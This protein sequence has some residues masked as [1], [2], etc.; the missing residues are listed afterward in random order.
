MYLKRRIF[1]IYQNQADD[2]TAGGGAGDKGD[3]GNKTGDDDIQTKI[4]AAV[5]TAVEGLT[6]K[7]KQLLAELKQERENLKKFEGIDP[8]KVKELM[9]KFDNDEDTK[10]IKEGKI[11][12][13]LNRKYSKRDAEWQRKLDEANKIA[14]EAKAKADKFLESVL[15]D[16]LR[17]AFNG[18]V[19]PRSMKA[20]LL[21]AKQLFT[22][23]DEGRAVQFDEEGQV[24]LGK[25]KTPFSPLEWIESETTRKESPYL[26]PATGAGSG[27]SQSSN[28]GASTHAEL[29]KLPPAERMA[30]AR[31]LNK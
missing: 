24:V 9:D 31:K 15:D 11:E 7:N 4:T 8:V 5:S 28:N 14:A 21:E 1:A 6:A 2:G 20:A 16:R 13:L 19:D 22:L 26:F 23:D 27:A 3:T 30:A 25:D 17:A 18:K 12:D 29:M 10:L